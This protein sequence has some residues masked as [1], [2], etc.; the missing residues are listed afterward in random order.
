MP[1]VEQCQEMLVHAQV[2]LESI[3][4]M[5]NAMHDQ[6]HALSEQR[7]REHWGKGGGDYDDESIHGEDMRNGGYGG[8]DSKK[9]R[10]VR[11]NLISLSFSSKN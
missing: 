3:H 4:R 7:M 11:L 5:K 1:S 9:R 6:E 8:G 2:V 10:G